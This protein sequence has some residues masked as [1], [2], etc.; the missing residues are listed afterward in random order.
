MW[1]LCLK[2]QYSRKRLNKAEDVFN[3]YVPCVCSS[4]S[5]CVGKSAS[6]CLDFKIHAYMHIPGVV[7]FPIR[8]VRGYL[9]LDV[10]MYAHMYNV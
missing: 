3:S 9:C 7:S 8:D 5:M 10:C 2:Y 6:I 4:G 1:V